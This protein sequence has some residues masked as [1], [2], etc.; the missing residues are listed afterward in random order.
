M[1]TTDQ[2]EVYTV[3]FLTY[4]D[5]YMLL[6]RSPNKKFAPGR[7]T[8][9]GGHVEPDE[10]DRLQYSALREVQEESGFAPEQIADFTLRRTLFVHWPGLSL[11]VVLYY[12]GRLAQRALPE[13]PEGTLHWIRPADFARYDIIETTRQ[14]LDRLVE[15]LR[16]DPTGREPVRSGLAVFD[17]GHRF[18]HIL[19]G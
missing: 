17:A 10:F 11:R 1:T 4:Q 14:V 8:G 7:W 5:Q 9:L 3:I 2:I 19:W 18:E 16:S 15:D 12:T 13:C 6:E